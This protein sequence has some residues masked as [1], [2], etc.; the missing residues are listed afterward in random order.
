MMRISTAYKMRVLFTNI[1]EYRQPC[2]SEA[3]NQALPI[4]AFTQAQSSN[5]KLLF[6]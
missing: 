2:F 3:W 6:S 5:F 4:H 1:A